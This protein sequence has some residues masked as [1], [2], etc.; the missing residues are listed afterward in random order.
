MQ[1]I[2]CSILKECLLNKDFYSKVKTI[3]EPSIFE[4]TFI[5]NLSVN[6]RDV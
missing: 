6:L 3:L 1:E 5:N 2:E 4:N